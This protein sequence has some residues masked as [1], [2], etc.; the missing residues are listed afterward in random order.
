MP[1]ARYKKQ[2][3]GRWKT[4]VWDGSYNPDGTKHKRTFVSSVSSADLE[5]KV[6]DFV[7]ARENNQIAIPSCISFVDYANRWFSTYKN[8]RSV[9]T[10]AM[11]RLVIDKH[12]LFLDGIALQDIRR[13]HFQALINSIQDHPR[14]CQQVSLAFK[15]VIRSAVSDNL[16]PFGSFD[17]ICQGIDLPKYT[18]S[19][20]RALTD[21][22]KV[23]IKEADFSPRERAF[24]YILYGCGL[25]RGE[26]LALTR[27][28]ISISRS[29]LSVNKALYFDGNTSGSKEPKT[30][31]SVRTVPMP[32]WLCAFLK[33]YLKTL[34][35]DS[36]FTCR[37]GPITRSSYA[38]MWRS[39][40]KK[41]NEAAGGT[42]NI[43]V[44]YGLTPH[45]FRHNYCSSLCYQIPQISIKKIAQ[46]LGDTEKMVL[47]V[48]SHTIE[49]KEAA[50]AAVDAAIGL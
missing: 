22:E 41:I 36:L 4:N 15:Q 28:D 45:I 24:V 47:E 43:Q 6:A 9:N 8:V 38:K 32:G 29:E 39:I 14:L 25:R 30:S 2:K 1:K 17:K 11:Y 40:V 23:A 20:R 37:T 18:P 26:A 3:D 33:D 35:G 44:I 5:R 7:H 49:K 46:L 19:E 31:N 21:E 27:F 50:K 48:Y 16:L 34:D 42:E 12:F 13:S 10:K